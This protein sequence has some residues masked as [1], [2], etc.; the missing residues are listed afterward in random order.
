MFLVKD[1]PNYRGNHFDGPEIVEIRLTF[2]GSTAVV[3]VTGELDLS[4]S[5]QLF[6][7]LHDAIDSGVSEVILDVAGLTYMDSTGLSILVGAHKRLKAAGGSFTVL[8][9]MHIVAKLFAVTDVVSC[10]TVRVA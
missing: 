3:T 1:P 9:P 8:A 2:S 10:L 5:A 6:E 7:C 4:N